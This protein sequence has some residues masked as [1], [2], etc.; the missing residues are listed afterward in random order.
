MVPSKR[1]ER[2][3]E[4]ALLLAPPTDR[5]ASEVLRQGTRECFPSE[6]DVYDTRTPSRVP[7]SRAGGAP[8]AGRRNSSTD[9]IRLSE[10]VASSSPS[11]LASERYDCNSSRL[12]SLSTIL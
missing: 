7:R 3:P 2:F 4:V 8:F 6:S 5:P 11:V 10:R 9:R 12:V 1:V